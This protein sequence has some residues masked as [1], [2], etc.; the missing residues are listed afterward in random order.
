MERYKKGLQYPAKEEREGTDDLARGQQL[1][2]ENMEGRVWITL[3][4]DFFFLRPMET[5]DRGTL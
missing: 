1:L 3:P 4:P 2:G 5:L